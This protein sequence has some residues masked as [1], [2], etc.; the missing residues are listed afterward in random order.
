ME[1]ASALKEGC[2]K[3]PGA[4]L[5]TSINRE[6]SAG[7][8]VVTFEGLDNHKIY[9]ALYTKHGIAAAPTGGVRFSPHIYNT[10]EEIDRT[11]AALSRIVKEV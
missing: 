9:E 5:R 10:L 1:L 3:I 6:L 8:C 11:I 4:R 7:I 2:S